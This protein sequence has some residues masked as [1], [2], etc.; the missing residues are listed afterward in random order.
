MTKCSSSLQQFDTCSAA[1]AKS[2]FLAC[3]QVSL[4]FHDLCNDAFAS[5]R[6]PRGAPPSLILS[7]SDFFWEPGTLLV[8][9]GHT[10]RALNAGNF[11]GKGALRVREL[12]QCCSRLGVDSLHVTCHDAPDL[13]DGPTNHWRPDSIAKVVGPYA[14]EHAI[15]CIVTF[16]SS[17]VSGHLNH[18]TLPA[19]V[20]EMLKR[21]PSTNFSEKSSHESPPL[22]PLSQPDVLVLKTV[23]VWRKYLGVWDVLVA[24]WQHGW[25]AEKAHDTH[26]RLLPMADSL[27][28]NFPTDVALGIY[29]MFAHASQLEWYRVLFVLFSSYT[30]LNT[31]QPLSAAKSE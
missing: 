18:C 6:Q 25:S 24:W 11:Y 1:T 8:N 23:P 14:T 28:V 4:N 19:G 12:H 22:P 15:D 2:T 20:L 13:L 5:E 27:V 9:F 7:V 17:G 29:A 3:L 10:C 31:L 26:S 21:W 30:Y 16:D